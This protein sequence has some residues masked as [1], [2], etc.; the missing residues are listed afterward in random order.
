M[1]LLT[2]KT[3]SLLSK[4]PFYVGL[5]YLLIFILALTA[6][7]F[8]YKFDARV[9]QSSLELKQHTEQKNMIDLLH[10]NMRERSLVLLQVVSTE[11]PFK[12]ESLREELYATGGEMIRL[13]SRY[14]EKPT[15]SNERILLNKVLDSSSENQKAQMMIVDLSTNQKS[16]KAIQILVRDSLP[17]QKQVLKAYYDLYNLKSSQLDNSLDNLNRDTKTIKNLWIFTLVGFFLILGFISYFT[18]RKLINS[19]LTNNKLRSQLEEK[20]EVYNQEVLL[21]NMVFQHIHEAIAITKE[22]G[23]IVYVNNGFKGIAPDFENRNFKNIWKLLFSLLPDLDQ[24]KIY[25]QITNES[26]SRQQIRLQGK[27]WLIDVYR[28]D[29]VR[30][31]E[32]YLTFTFTDITL[33][34]ETEENLEKLANYDNVTNLPNRHFFQSTLRSWIQENRVFSLLFIDL[35]NFKWINDTLGHFAGDRVLQQVATALKSRIPINENSLIARIGGDEFAVLTTEYNERKLARFANTIINLVR[36][37][38][39]LNSLTKPLGA[40]IGVASFPK[41]SSTYED[42]LRFADFAMYQSKEMGR[43]TYNLFSTEMKIH[44]DMLYDREADLREAIKNKEL[45]LVY[46]PQFDLQ[47]LELI[48]AEALLRWQKGSEFIP[49]SEF[50]PLAER[51]GLINELGS[52]VFKQG[53]SQVKIWNNSEHKVPRLA[54]NV[55][56]VQLNDSKFTHEL[57]VRLNHYQIDPNQIDLEITESLLM[58]QSNFERSE[59]S[60]LQSYGME[61]SIDDFGT[62]YSSLAYIK[63]LDVDRIKIDRSFIQ[64]LAYG[65]DSIS[66]VTAIIKM[67]HS[68]GLKVLA[69]GIET[70]E[71]LEILRELGCDEGQG[72]FLGRPVR[73]EEFSHQSLISYSA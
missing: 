45:F 56:S 41:D 31:D 33:I 9:Q 29:D 72:F 65:S 57:K 28:F 64:D 68:L 49:P 73:A 6:S 21:S 3:I 53:L 46:Q 24:G 55:S 12:K 27:Y 42:L 7:F 32:T 35:D 69:E 34:K 10:Q 19:E 2:S 13:L 11:D 17:A 58:D 66:I 62:G 15:S 50:I 20:L 1:K 36:Q 18:I 44:M 48:G 25:Q 60:R 16:D 4:T 70:R 43:N 59:L 54:I 47:N 51:F 5:G 39:D 8:A 30:L 23:E 63:N 61:I 67:G 14:Q 26:Y 22:D 40:S 38:P 52:F 37:A 71:Q